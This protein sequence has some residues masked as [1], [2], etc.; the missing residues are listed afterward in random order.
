MFTYASERTYFIQRKDTHRLSQVV[1]MVELCWWPLPAWIC[2][3]VALFVFF[4]VLVGA[5]AVLS[6]EQ[7]PGGCGPASRRRLCRSAS[8][9][10]LDRLRSFS[11]FPIH[12]TAECYYHTLRQTDEPPLPEPVAAE[13]QSAA[14]AAETAASMSETHTDEAEAEEKSASSDEDCEQDQQHHMPEK[15][16]P[17]APDAADDD[18]TAG[19]ERL[20]KKNPRKVA[21]RRARESCPDEDDEAE[22]KAELNARADLFIQQFREDLKL[23][24]LNSIINYTRALRNGA[25][26]RTAVW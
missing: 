12:P 9:M 17:P 13:P 16:S 20:G 24:R 21:K 11:M 4:N 5:V 22:G 18:A 14:A 19:S 10:V 7:Q 2:P 26:A 15:F 6:R 25:G 3:G 1:A 23:Q 8:S